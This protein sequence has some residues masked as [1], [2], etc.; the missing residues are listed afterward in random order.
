MNES[1]VLLSAVTAG[2]TFNLSDGEQ[3]RLIEHDL[4]LPPVTRLTRRFP[5]QHGD[6][7][8]GYRYQPRF[9]SLAW[10]VNGRNNA[11]YIGLKRLLG[12]VFVARDQPVTLTFGLIDGGAEEVISIDCFL[13]G[14]LLETERVESKGILSGV[15]RCPDPRFYDPLLRHTTFSLG[16][17]GVSGLGWE[18]PWEVPWQ[19]G[20]YTLSAQ[21]NILYAG[22]RLGAAPEF[23]RITIFGPIDNPTITNITT[24]ETLDFSANGGLELEAGETVDI[25]LSGGFTREGRRVVDKDGNSLLPYLTPE[26]D[27]SIWHLSPRGETLFNN[28]I[29]NGLNT[30]VADGE[31][32][33]TATRVVITY[34]NRYWIP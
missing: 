1:P 30:I 5:L 26:S 28:A 19:V 31:A 6:V 12:H 4:S 23:P 17:I 15:F 16:G 3:L 32:V 11:E 7:D 33:T 24:G 13:D 21:L 20:P 14:T 27:F 9:L 18:V 2:E 10:A 22:G 25:W 8:T 29:S 34:A